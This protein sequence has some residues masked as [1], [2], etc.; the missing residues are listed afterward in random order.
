ML[1]CVFAQLSAPIR[2]P[3]ETEGRKLE[4][5]ANAGVCQMFSLKKEAV[6]S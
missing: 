2:L 3:E 4:F 6:R 5:N 1:L